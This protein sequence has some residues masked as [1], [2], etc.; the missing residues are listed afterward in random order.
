MLGTSC[1]DAHTNG[2]MD[3]GGAV[4][5]ALSHSG[6]ARQAMHAHT[7]TQSGAPQSLTFPVSLYRSQDSDLPTLISSVHRSRH[8][9]MPEHQSRCEFQRGSVE[10]GLGAAGE[11]PG[12]CWGWGQGCQG[13]AAQ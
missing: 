7:Q 5:E 8:L 11:E 9:V 3:H 4:H 13:Q 1:G 12:Q 2:V 6:A 10:I